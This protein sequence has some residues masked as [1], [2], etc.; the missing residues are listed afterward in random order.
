MASPHQ[1]GSTAQDGH[2]RRGNG[3]PQA[4]SP[5]RQ[6]LR[7]APSEGEREGRVQN[8]F[9]ARSRGRRSPRKPGP[10]LTWSSIVVRRRVERQ[11]PSEVEGAANH[12]LVF[13]RVKA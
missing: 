13:A 2:H 10:G 4:R 1:A 12:P 7:T 8:I 6:P 9:R 3:R 11:C 5:P